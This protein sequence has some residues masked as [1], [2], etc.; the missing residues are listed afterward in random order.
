MIDA[1]YSMLTL[2]CSDQIDNSVTQLSSA[3]RLAKFNLD[4]LAIKS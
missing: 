4:Q 3:E 1:E 2:D